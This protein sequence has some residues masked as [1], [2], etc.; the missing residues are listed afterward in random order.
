ME[1]RVRVGLV[2]GTEFNF[3]KDAES[4]EAIKKEI[5]DFAEPWYEYSYDDVHVSFKMDSMVSLEVSEKTTR[6]IS[7]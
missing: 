2:N 7:L 6:K 4:A 3:V 5:L 1:Y